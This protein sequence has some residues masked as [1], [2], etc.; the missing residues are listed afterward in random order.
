MR[1]LLVLVLAPGLIAATSPPAAKRPLTHRDY[2]AWRTI[3]R[4]VL[5]RDGRFL[6]YSY[7]PE[8]GDGELVV[9][10]LSTGKEKREGVGA[11][12]PPPMV[13]DETGDD[14]PPP[15]AVRI[16]F[17]NDDAF[18]VA[19]TY[20]TKAE[21]DEAKKQKKKAEEMPKGG[22]VIVNLASGQATRV[23][24]VKSMDV[25]AKGGA[26]LAYLKEAPPGAKASGEGDAESQAQA[27]GEGRSSHR[28]GGARGQKKTE[29]GTDLVVRDL[30]RG[31]E[32]TIASVLDYHFARDGLTLLYAVSSRQGE[33]NGV[34]ALTPG[35]DAAP[36]AL[37]TGKGRYLKLVWDREQTR[38]A[39][40][41]D[42]DDE[43][44]S[45]KPPRLKTYLWSRGGP[46]PKEVV[47]SSTSGFPQTFAISDNGV[48]AF[49]RDGKALYVP[50]AP[51]SKS[52]GDAD[53]DDKD[54]D[55]DSAPSDDNVRADLWHWKDDVVQPMQ[56][57]RANQERNRT[58]RGVYHIAEG[59]YV[60]LADMTL[61][62]T[63]PSDDGMW[64]IGLDDRPYRRL[65]DYDGIYNDVYVVDATSGSRT[66]AVK[67]LRGGG[68]GG[69][70]GAPG[71]EGGLQWSPD[72]RHAVFF[73]D[74]NWHLIDAANGSTRDLTAQLGVAVYN[75]DEDRPEPPNSYGSAGWTRDSASF[76]AYDRYDVWQI[77]ADGRPARNLT[78]GQGR[79][80]RIE[81]RVERIEPQEEDND[82]RGLDPGT[83]LY[84]RAVSEESRASGFY[85][86]SFA[87]HV[88]PQRLLWGDKNY[89][90][91]G[92]AQQADV[93]LVT[94]SRFDEFPDVYTTDSTFAR[95]GKVSN[96]GAQLAPFQWGSAELMTYQN[97]DGVSLKAAL[98]KPYG[99]DPKKKYPM[100]IFLYERLSQNVNNFVNPA[101]GT[102]INI[103]YYVSNGYLVLTPD[104]VYSVGHPGQSALK[105]VLPAIQSVVDRGFV[106][107]NNIGIQGHS[108]GGYQTAYMITQT[109]RF[110]AAEAGAPVGNMTSAYSGI[111]WGSGQPRQVQYEQTQSRIARP[112]YEA[113]LEYLENSPIFHVQNVQTPLLILHN[114]NDDAVPWYQGIELYLAL[115]RYGKEVY[116]WS[117]NGELHSLRRR[118]DQ[119]DYTVRMQQFFDHF[120]KGA[121]APEWME[122][123]IPYIER[124]EEKERFEKAVGAD[125]SH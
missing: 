45:V 4:P 38:A 112:L 122:K 117:Y 92:R 40:L 3:N 121:P 55:K 7:M 65:G 57:V 12:P 44:A 26:W 84:L 17:T 29:Y 25:P 46:A 31:Q 21:T 8:E 74:K 27:Q 110:K 100:M 41:S 79:K 73:Q 82:E 96:G 51:P 102:S 32:R 64:A 16:A 111:R 59:K 39:F 20:P 30:V 115:R 80:D 2:D 75:E 22:L 18:V 70:G 24:S 118:Y 107:E 83:P 71:R 36:A 37:L 5:S 63:N 123:G 48:L 98:Y 77:F 10:E 23:A 78:A 61:R 114:D 90:Y 69:G 87:G 60:Q 53:A 106:D 120:L 50:T 88:A 124:D 54:K 125:G 85:K 86:T 103:P 1:R 108:W 97:A 89:R 33:D 81:F 28:G 95:L 94:A 93:L 52:T 72:G 119:K 116:L 109:R 9:R 113:P 43:A 11:L 34:Y 101:P 99:F 76:V 19:T 42:R 35:T 62:T 68:A 14:P 67:R 15:R 6:A 56:R 47:A 49:S 66:L 13:S 58:Y 104:I 105:C 91:V